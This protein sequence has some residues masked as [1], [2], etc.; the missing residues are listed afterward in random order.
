MD[1]LF[2]FLG[3][4]G[5]VFIFLEDS[6]SVPEEFDSDAVGREGVGFEEAFRDLGAVLLDDLR[7]SGVVHAAWGAESGVG[8]CDF[9]HG[10]T[11][12]DFS[13]AEGP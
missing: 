13:V 9:F 6:G 8:R 4:C 12:R 5:K 7:D 11:S 10:R 3:D 1:A 2:D